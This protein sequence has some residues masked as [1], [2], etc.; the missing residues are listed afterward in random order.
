MDFKWNLEKFI[1]IVIKNL[2]YYKKKLVWCKYEMNLIIL[3]IF[4]IFNI[5]M[6]YEFWIKIYK[7]FLYKFESF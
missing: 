1:E 3:N 4:Y 2:K 7:D 6:K 5:Y